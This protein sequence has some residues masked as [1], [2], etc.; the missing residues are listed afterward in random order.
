MGKNALARRQ[1][2]AAD[3]AD[4]HG[5]TAAVLLITLELLIN[6]LLALIAVPSEADPHQLRLE[7][8]DQLA[9]LLLLGLPAA[10]WNRIGQPPAG[11][12]RIEPWPATPEESPTRAA[13]RAGSEAPTDSRG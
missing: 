10:D 2:I 7:L 12:G 1:A 13:F 3:L 9:I 8:L 5:Q 4:Q 11:V 6:P